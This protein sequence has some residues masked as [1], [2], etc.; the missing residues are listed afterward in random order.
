[1]RV[2]IELGIFD[3]GDVLPTVCLADGDTKDSLVLFRLTL[4]D[5]R[6]AAEKEYGRKA[7]DH[8]IFW[9]A[10][11]EPTEPDTYVPE[12]EHGGES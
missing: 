4:H 10:H 1:M 12:P 5:L 9:R 3:D 2:L 6:A 7:P 11:P 8:A